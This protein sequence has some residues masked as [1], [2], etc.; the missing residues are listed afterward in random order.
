[1]VPLNYQ[2]KNR[3]LLFFFGQKKYVVPAEEEKITLPKLCGSHQTAHVERFMSPI[4]MIFSASAIWADSVI[5]NIRLYVVVHIFCCC[6]FHSLLMDLGQDQQQYFPVHSGGVSRGRVRGCD[7][8]HTLRDLVSPVCGIFFRSAAAA[9]NLFKL[10]GQ[11]P[12]NFQIM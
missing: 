9:I 8:P 6:L 2:N 12:L 1:M 3:F 4:C 5:S 10:S 7:Y 11:S